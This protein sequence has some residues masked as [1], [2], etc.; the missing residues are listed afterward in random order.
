MVR[1]ALGT[2][3]PCFSKATKGN[4]LCNC[5]SLGVEP[6]VGTRRACSYFRCKVKGRLMTKASVCA[7]YKDTC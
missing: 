4:G 2:R 3:V 6:K 1:V 5:A 7:A